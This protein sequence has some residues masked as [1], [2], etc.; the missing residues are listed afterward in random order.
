MFPYT[1]L[2]T[3]SNCQD[4]FLRTLAD[5]DR[6]SMAHSWCARQV[7]RCDLAAAKLEL[8]TLRRENQRLLADS[9][10]QSARVRG[11]EVQQ[12]NVPLVLLIVYPLY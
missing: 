6:W 9:R 4:P 3:Y 8:K 12:S 7:N 1:L 2:N 11:L 5:S 10:R